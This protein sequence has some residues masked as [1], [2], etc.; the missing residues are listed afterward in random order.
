MI[1]WSGLQTG[2]VGHNALQPCST[3]S[4]FQESLL[5]QLAWNSWALPW[6]LQVLQKF[7]LFCGRQQIPDPPSPE[8]L[9]HWIFPPANTYQNCIW[10]KNI[11]VSSLPHSNVQIYYW[12]EPQ[13]SGREKSNFN[14]WRVLMYAFVV[15][16]KE[17]TSAFHSPKPQFSTKK[18][19]YLK[20]FCISEC[21]WLSRK[22]KDHGSEFCCL[23]LYLLF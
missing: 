2:S 4:L 1:F 11:G 22:K 13:G 18:E 20:I 3:G 19:K 16:W 7:A 10:V 6:R 15:P 8:H 12:A 14:L 9:S 21:R 23:Y 5:P 17:K